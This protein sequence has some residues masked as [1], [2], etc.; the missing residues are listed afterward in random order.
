MYFSEIDTFLKCFLSRLFKTFHKFVSKY[1]CIGI[2]LKEIVLFA[3]NVNKCTSTKQ[4]L[5]RN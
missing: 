5:T 2:C 4:K 1:F 3:T